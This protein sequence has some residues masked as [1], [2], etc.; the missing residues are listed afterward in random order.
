MSID[1]QKIEQLVVAAVEKHFAAVSTPRSQSAPQPVSSVESSAPC[2]VVLA[3]AVVTADLLQ[4]K[5][6]GRSKFQIGDRTVLTPSAHDF[7]RERGLSWSR[8]SAATGLTDA[9]WLAA[10]VTTGP[11]AATACGQL[12]SDWKQELLGCVGEA[13]RLAVS[14]ISRA[15]VVGAAVLTDAPHATVCLANRSPN[16]RAAVVC[17]LDDLV[18]A[19]HELGANVVAIDP[20]RIGSFQLRQLLR[21]F[22]ESGA[23]QPPANWE[24]LSRLW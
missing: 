14:E 17:G 22:S 21:R 19:K 9:A 3:D 15:D 5:I 24:T 12:G 7:I 10:V 16:I 1:Q 20:T 8:L 13:V 18:A 11:Q 23:P 6:N 2:E 4:E